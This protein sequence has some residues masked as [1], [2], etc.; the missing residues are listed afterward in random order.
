MNADTVEEILAT[1]Q[2]DDWIYKPETSDYTY[3]KD[4]NLRIKGVTDYSN[5]F[6]ERWAVRHPDPKALRVTCSIF[7][8]D[9]FVLDKYLVSVDGGRATLPMP[10]TP[11]ELTVTHREYN[12]SRIIDQGM[13]RLDE[14][15]E[16]S[17]ISIQR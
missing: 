11:T 1:S 9:S 5:V 12:F 16:R 7:Y 4:L 10:K 6:S 17:G 13:G 14:Y 15:L 8:R 3:K 2:P